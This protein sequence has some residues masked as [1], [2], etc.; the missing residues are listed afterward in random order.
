MSH[1]PRKT[2]VLYVTTG[3]PTEPT[4]E[5]VRA[6]TCPFLSDKR[7]VDLPRAQWWPI[8]HWCIL[9]HR[10]PKT[11]LRY[12]EIWM[13]GGSPLLVYTEAQR[14][15]LERLL[16]ARGHDDVPVVCA[17]RY[18]E[19]SVAS[20]IERLTGEL[21]CER[22]IVL[23]VYPQYA[24]VTNG[25]MLQEVFEALSRLKRIPSVD[26][27]DSFADDEAYLDALAAHIAR[28]WTYVDDGRHK[29]VF[30]FH[31]TLVADVENGDVYR[32]Q[33]EATVRAIARRLGIPERGWAFGYQSVFDHRPW[34]EPLTAR[35]VLPKLAEE[36]VTDV[37]VVA[38]GFTAECLETHFDVDVEQREAFE[39]RVPDGTFTYVPCLNDDPAFLEALA[40]IVEAHIVG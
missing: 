28:R 25:T 40:G 16:A 12:Q 18:G 37:A 35:D 8:L 22:I 9:P 32:E 21:G 19:P 4:A 30:T 3:S 15:G 33:I 14:A 38:P 24:S 20:G 23:P 11:A 7:I 5:G 10:S 34:L 2:G 36:G 31:S 13:D 1:R 26:A 6:W 17:M 27:I 29:L 39:S